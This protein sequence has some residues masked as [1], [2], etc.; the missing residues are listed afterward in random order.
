MIPGWHEITW[1]HVLGIGRNLGAGGPCK[2]TLD[3]TGSLEGNN[4]RLD[5]LLLRHR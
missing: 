5:E 2:L 4:R 1:T 3:A